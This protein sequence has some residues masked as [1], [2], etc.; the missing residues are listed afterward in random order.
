MPKP[1]RRELLTGGAAG[2]ALLAAKTP[3]DAFGK[4]PKLTIRRL[5]R[6]PS[7]NPGEKCYVTWRNRYSKDIVILW[8]TELG[9][10]KFSH[11]LK[12]GQEMKR[13]TLNRHRYEAYYLR[14]DYTLA[15][16]YTKSKPLSHTVVSPDAVWEIKPPGK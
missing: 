15:E 11:H 3:S 7:L 1:S 5:K 4:P 2:A 16:Q 12:P 9:G 6:T 8:V 10:V 13:D 14:K